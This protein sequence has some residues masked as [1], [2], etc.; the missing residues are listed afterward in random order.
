[1]D[2][3]IEDHDTRRLVPQGRDCDNQPSA[4][5]EAQRDSVAV[6]ERRVF[7]GFAEDD[8]MAIDGYAIKLDVVA[9]RDSSADE[10]N[11]LAAVDATRER[12]ARR[13]A[14]RRHR[15]RTAGTVCVGTTR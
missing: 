15:E 2:D 8:R 12:Q 9:S 1:L 11:Y 13:G 10:T 4:G 5:I 14:G 7:A 3:V 6:H